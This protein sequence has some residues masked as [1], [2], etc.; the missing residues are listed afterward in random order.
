MSYHYACRVVPESPRWL[1]IQGREEEAKAV[2]AR[3]ARGNR[4]EMVSCRLKQLTTGPTEKTNVS[5][6]DLFRGNEIQ[7]RTV[8]LLIAW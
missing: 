3:I 8:L 6:L 4:T 1:L 2:L 5:V 7:R